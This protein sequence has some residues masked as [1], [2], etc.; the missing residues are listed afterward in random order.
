[1]SKK[2]LQVLGGL[3]AACALSV[4]A[5][6]GDAAPTVSADAQVVTRDAAT[7]KL[8]AATPEEMSA[9]GVGRE[10]ATLRSSL[11]GR[12]GLAVKL[13]RSGATGVRATDEMASYSVVTKQADGS[14]AKACVETQSAAEAAVLTGLVPAQ[15]AAVE[16]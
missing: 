15:T 4:P 1:M 13:H 5:W 11:G 10:A 7:G 8:R 16:K 9:L 14:L 12:A 2:T 3:V 6:A